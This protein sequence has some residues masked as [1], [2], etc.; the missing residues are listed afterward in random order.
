MKKG[1]VHKAREIF[2]IKN[3]IFNKLPYAKDVDI[4]IDRTEGGGYESHIKLHIPPKKHLLATKK[5]ESLKQALEK[6]KQA[7]LRQIDKVK[8][9]RISKKRKGQLELST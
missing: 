2:K 9:K 5:D 4:R 3:Q 7:I 8:M 6:S 1:K